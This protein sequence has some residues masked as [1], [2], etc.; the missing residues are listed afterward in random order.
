MSHS[1]SLRRSVALIATAGLIATGVAAPALARTKGPAKITLTAKA[2]QDPAGRL[3][4]PKTTLGKTATRE[5][6]ET[7]CQ[8]RADWETAGVTFVVK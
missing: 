8:T 7:I 2:A 1:T 4:M 3:C 6:P 5:M